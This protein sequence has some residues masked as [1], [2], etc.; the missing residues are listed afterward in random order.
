VIKSEEGIRM[1]YKIQ[2]NNL[3][4][5]DTGWHKLNPDRVNAIALHHMAHPTAGMETIHGWHLNRWSDEPGF[6]YNY[7][8]TL[9]GEIFKGRGNYRGSHVRDRNSITVGIGFQG[10]YHPIDNLAHRE[11]MPDA[12]FNAG[13]WLIKHL[14]EKDF[15]NVRTVHEHK[16]FQR[17]TACAGKFFPVAE[18]RSL[19][20]REEIQ[21]DLPVSFKGEVISNTL[22]VRVQPTT[23]SNILGEY[24]KGDTFMVSEIVGQEPFIWLKTDKGYVSNA[25]WEYVKKIVKWNGE[26]LSDT[27][28]VRNLP[29]M[30]GEVIGQ[31][32][33]G[34][35]LDVYAVHGDDWKWLEIGEGEYVSNKDD[36]YVE[37]L[38]E[39]EGDDEMLKNAIL[40]GSTDDYPSASRLGR[41]IDAPV[42][43]RGQEDKIVAKTLYVVGGPK[44]D[45]SHV[46]KIVHLSGKDYFETARKVNEY[47]KG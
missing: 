3:D 16:N 46:D 36:H 34:E 12:Q 40:I 8:V 5:R 18:M 23:N 30:D 15:P 44:P 42:Y 37:K 19:E 33:K 25:R 14:K 2:E 47:L 45:N 27:L 35:I 41:K 7:F 31:V 13:V 28:N 24:E 32:K 29:S 1:N 6:A 38:K 10:N 9:K 22:N 39:S 17:D 20:Y 21:E 4:W 26:V 11:K 43:S